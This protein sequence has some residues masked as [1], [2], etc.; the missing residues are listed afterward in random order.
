MILETAR[1][2]T[3]VG[4]Q[5]IKDL[6]EGPSI[7][8]GSSWEQPAD[9]TWKPQPLLELT[10]ESGHRL[11]CGEDHEV[12]I[13]GEQGYMFLP[14]AQLTPAHRVCLSPPQPLEFGASSMDEE[15]AFYLA[16]LVTRANAVRLNRVVV[17]FT[18][19]VGNATLS[20]QAEG[21]LRY[22]EGRGYRAFGK[23]DYVQRKARRRVSTWKKNEPW[24][25]LLSIVVQINDARYHAQLTQWGLTVT[26]P[27]KERLLPS[28]AWALP[29]PLRRAFVRGLILANAEVTTRNSVCRF[30]NFS[31]RKFAEEAQLILRTIGMSSR[32]TQRSRIRL[33]FLHS[34]ATACGLVA[35]THARIPKDPAPPWVLRTILENRDLVPA[36]PRG[37]RPASAPDVPITESPRQAWRRFRRYGEVSVTMARTFAERYGIP[38]QVYSSAQVKSVNK[39]GM[40]G[41][42]YTI[43]GPDRYDAQGII[44]RAG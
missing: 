29:L 20:T 21:F 44:S 41:L 36:L 3:S 28:A 37:R 16:I 11:E 18:D 23:K 39:T 9:C 32:L 25:Y 14:V 26:K 8:T 2:L 19:G 5:P 24:S 42:V 38:V 22:L 35:P 17:A 43:A 31:N 1:V 27:A 12:L 15:D 6:A 13:E 30:M 34:E 7:W 40:Q 33:S 4:Y 10:L